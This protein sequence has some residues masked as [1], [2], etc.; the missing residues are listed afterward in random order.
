L[1]LLLLAAKLALTL[2]LVVQLSALV[3]ANL[4][5]QMQAYQRHRRQQRQP[6]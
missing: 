5:A 4:P 2:V 3:Q 6:L 1:Q